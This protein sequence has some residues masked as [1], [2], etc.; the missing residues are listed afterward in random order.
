M[1]STVLNG[2][3]GYLAGGIKVA[4]DQVYV[5]IRNKTTG[6]ISAQKLN[7]DLSLAWSSDYSG[8]N[9]QAKALDVDGLGN[10]IVGVQGSYSA[11]SLVGFDVDGNE[12]WIQSAG[13]GNPVFLKFGTTGEIY[14]AGTFIGPSDS[15][16][17]MNRYGVTSLTCQ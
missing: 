4:G 8:G 6:V 11:L 10:M 15:D 1:T 14:L 17:F 12:A 9:V 5:T 2:T 3:D 13:S 16:G 7:A